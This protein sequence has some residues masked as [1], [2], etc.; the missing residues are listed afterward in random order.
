MSANT[1]PYQMSLAPWDLDD[2]GN[3]GALPSD[4]WGTVALVTG[5]S[6]QT[7]TLA[8]PTKAGLQLTLAFKTDGGGDC[9][10]TVATGGVNQ[11]ANT[12]LTFA[13]AG[14]EI[15]LRSIPVGSGYRW[16]VVSNDGVALA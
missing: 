12:S 2:P 14:D 4:Q 11:S 15:T 5:S 6:G 8:Q 7:R 1:T 10:V 9:V 3:A 16:R 13:D